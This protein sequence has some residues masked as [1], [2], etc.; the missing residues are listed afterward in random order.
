MLVSPGSEITV[1]D[2]SQYVSTAVGTVPFILMATAENKLF[3]GSIA[4]YSTKVNAGK[5]LAVTSQRDLIT[6]FG[7]PEF[8]ESAAGTP[9]HGHQLNEYGLMTAYSALGTVNRMFIIRADIDLAQLEGT[10]VRPIGEPSNGTY[11]LDLTNTKWG[12]FQ[13]D[14]TAQ[15]FAPVSPLVITSS[16][17]TFSNSGILTPVSTVGQ[18]GSYAVIA[19]SSNNYIF[20]KRKDNIW[21]QVGSQQW[22]DAFPTLTGTVSVTGMVLTP[23]STVTLN[24]VVVTLTGSDAYSAVANINSAAI[25]G[26]TA[27]VVNDRVELYATSAALNGKLI[28]AAGSVEAAMGINITGTPVTSYP[29]AMQYGGYVGVPDWRASDSQ[30]R[31][32]GSVWMKTSVLGGGA[33]L[34]FKKYDSEANVWNTQTTPIY[35][36][37]SD[38]IYDLDPGAGGFGIE[39]GTIYIHQDYLG[40]NTSSF[41]P[42]IKTKSGAMSVTGTAPLT[43]SVFTPGDQFRVRYSTPGVQAIQAKVITL[44]GTD[45]EAFVNSILGAFMPDITAQLNSDGSITISHL[46]GGVITLENI[47]GT[48]LITAGFTSATLNVET[49]PGSTSL[50]LSNFKPLVYTYSASKPYTAPADGTLWFYNSPLDVDIMV[51]DAS[52]WKGYR[53]V[54]NDARGYNLQQTD[55][56]GVLLSPTAPLTQSTGNGLVKGDLWINTGDLD[57]FPVISRYTGTKWQLVDNTDVVTQNGIVFADARWDLNGTA[58][59]VAGALPKI[60]DLLTSNYT[61]LDAPDYRLYPRGT[62]LF[63]L[64]RSGYNVKH[65]VSNYFNDIAYPN[66]SVLPAQKATWVTSSGLKNDGS[67]YAGRHAQRVMITRAMKAALDGNET[68]REESFAFNLLAAPGY[69][70]LISNMVM[71][72]NDRK[73][74]GFI[75][76]D[77]PMDLPAKVMDITAWSTNSTGE[78]LSTADPYLGV[79]Y[80]SGLA[81]DLQGNTIVMPPSHMIL[82]A[83]I[84]SD[85]VSYPWFAYAGLRRGLIDNATDIGYVNPAN[86]SFVRNGVN[87]GLRDAL[88][89]LNINPLT[90]L[91]AVGLVNFGNKTRQGYSSSMDRV[92]VA[93]LINYIRTILAHATDA[94]L[95][96]PNDA[97]TRNQVKQVIS[98]A[99]ND[100]IVKRG[101]YDYLVICDESNNDNARIARNELYVDVAIEPMKAVEFIYIPIRL[102]NP[103]GIKS[104]GK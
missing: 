87:Q 98:N 101:V 19:N 79:Y 16:V 75:I 81:N 62:L 31:P 48:P 41:K 25:S 27:A 54:P 91:P 82:R 103:G 36:S 23:G 30:P 67:P 3:N 34:V 63:N 89:Q 35:Q 66:A 26:V 68:V 84:K 22:Q 11:W 90:L 94:F 21:V 7:Y 88:Y 49:V 10:A 6:N 29:P 47:I 76:G 42:Y 59:P 13:W 46:Q 72:N 5:L 80:P 4:Q 86:G 61:D 39:A 9:L 32:S 37:E 44:T 78:G 74:T 52:G 15:E 83:A 64:R 60:S 69:P 73:N 40:N 95:F 1:I 58:D 43:P 96:E 97:I 77:T 102:K 57:H 8:K 92:N 51:N 12:I 71:L 99:L 70:E 28:V 2:E 100:L 45:S 53:N 55:P 85:Y 38:A 65:F 17:S 56:Q 50:K 93:R 104:S 33:S 20:Y 18:V 14:A 24:N